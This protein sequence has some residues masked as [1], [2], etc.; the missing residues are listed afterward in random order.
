LLGGDTVAPSGLYARLCHA[1]LVLFNYTFRHV[2]SF[3][4]I[5]LIDNCWLNR[6]PSNSLLLN[7]VSDKLVVNISAILINFRQKSNLVIALNVRRS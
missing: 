3:V 1:F 5:L 7:V 4:S 2:L 6:L